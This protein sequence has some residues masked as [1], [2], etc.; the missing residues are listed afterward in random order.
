[1]RDK[2]L[3]RTTANVTKVVRVA[4]LQMN[5]GAD[6]IANLATV[7]R[8]LTNA[9]EIDLLLL[10]EN[11][12][13][14]PARRSEQ[15]IESSGGVLVQD[16]LGGLSAEFSVNILAG[17]V[18]IYDDESGKPF[19]RSLMFNTRG[20]LCG[21]YDKIH[22][23]DVDVGPDKTHRYRESDTYQHGDITSE[24]TATVKLKLIGVY[25]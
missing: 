10:P 22:L 14:M 4:C 5:S 17:S 18:A 20:Q 8:A 3:K 12:A 9:R 23:F 16:T 2:H 7:R 11:F 19:A 21:Q 13:Q 6:V 15:H 25:L 24:Q 1:M